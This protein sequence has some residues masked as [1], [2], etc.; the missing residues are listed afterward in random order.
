[1]KREGFTLFE[2]LLAVSILS[3]G[4]IAISQCFMNSASALRYIS[5]RTRADLIISDRVWE[6]K[7]YINRNTV[8]ADYTNQKSEGSNPTFNTVVR[9]KRSGDPSRVYALQVTVSWSEGRKNVLLSYPL[10]IMKKM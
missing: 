4:V 6:M 7:D 5:N 9:M 8:S 3:I 2:I 1:M 10:C